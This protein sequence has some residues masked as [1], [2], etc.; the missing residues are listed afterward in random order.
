MPHTPRSVPAPGDAV[1]SC[2]VEAPLED[3]VWRLFA[4]L[5]RD[6]PAGFRIAALIR[7]PHEGEDRERWLGR[8][9]EAAERGPLGQHT[10]FGR[11]NHGWPLTAGDVDR[12]REE[13]EWLR[14]SGVAPTLFCGGAWY[15]D[16]E[17]AELAVECGYADC[18]ALAFRP[19][20]LE[21]GRTY[22]HVDRPSWLRLPSGTR[23]L[24]LPSTHSIGMLAR[25]LMR[26]AGVAAPLVHAYFH[27]T[28]LLDPR[29]R[30]L[31]SFALRLLGARRRPTD[32]DALRA[33]DA[34]V[35]YEEAVRS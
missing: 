13:A 11:P 1:V 19:R 26:P 33:A 9:R 14:E 23:L 35:P 10:H 25:A 15:M 30:T 3:A 8:A 32:L 7:P 22:L 6:R 18:T 4:R 17:V 20:Y 12:A 27:D 31:I 16:A 5:Q 28:D 29:R 2:H 34:E 21:R 24:E